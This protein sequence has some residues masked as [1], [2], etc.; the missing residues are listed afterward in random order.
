MF[1]D[2]LQDKFKMVLNITHEAAA[3]RAI[4]LYSIASTGIDGQACF[5]VGGD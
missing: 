2:A 5:E 3:E 1:I 4:N